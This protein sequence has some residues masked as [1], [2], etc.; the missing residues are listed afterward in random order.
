MHVVW[1]FA[2]D[3]GFN[4]FKVGFV[5]SINPQVM[6]A[7][8]PVKNESLSF[9][10]TPISALT[11]YYLEGFLS[12]T[13]PSNEKLWKTGMI[14]YGQ[15]ITRSHMA[16]KDRLDAAGISY[17]EHSYGKLLFQISTVACILVL[18]MLILYS[19]FGKPAYHRNMW[20]VR[21]SPVFLD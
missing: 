5:Y 20:I 14:R 12:A 18:L 1:G 3:F 4:G 13:T 7:F 19:V 17:F 21:R 10:M 11:S 6:D 2:K 16:V 15:E 8:V 9:V